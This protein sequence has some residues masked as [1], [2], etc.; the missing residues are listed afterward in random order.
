MTENKTFENLHKLKEKYEKEYR[1]SIL[2]INEIPDSQKSVCEEEPGIFENSQIFFKLHPRPSKLSFSREYEYHK[3]C[4]RRVTLDGIWAEFGCCKGISVRYL[5]KLKKDIFP[6][7]KKLIYGFD[8]FIGLPEDWEGQGTKK[9]GLS[10]NGVVPNIEG[11]KFYK[12]WFKDTIPVFLEEHEGPFSFLHIDCDIYSS[13]VDIL[14]LAEKRIVPGTVILFDELIGYDAWKL[15]EYK[16]F[17]EFVDRHD[18]KF[19]WIA[20]VA[21]A[22]QAACIITDRK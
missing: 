14:T 5:T 16:A 11:A 13:T 19:D 2:R 12:G 9:G 17:R 7:C 21:N 22:G 6:N 3:H 15:N 10:A 4:I 18:V 8:S 1:G 20:A